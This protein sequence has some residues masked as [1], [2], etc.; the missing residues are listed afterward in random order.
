MSAWRLLPY[1]SI[2]ICAGFQFGTVYEHGFF[3]KFSVFWQ[4]TY[5]L[6]E[7]IFT[8][9]CQKSCTESC[10]L[11]CLVILNYTMDCG[12]FGVR[13]LF[14]ARKKE[15]CKI[16]YSSILQQPQKNGDDSEVKS[17]WR[18]NSNWFEFLFE[19]S[20]WNLSF[21]HKLKKSGRMLKKKRRN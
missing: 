12:L 9:F 4:P 8:G 14:M 20:V 21:L 15:P 13:F 6:I 19:F 11:K 18:R 5:Q 1:K 17:K 16:D 10:N 2:F 3:W 7:E